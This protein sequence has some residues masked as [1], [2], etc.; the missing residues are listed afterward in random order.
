M[1]LLKRDFFFGHWRFFFFFNHWSSHLFQSNQR[2]QGIEFVDRTVPEK[3]Y[4]FNLPCMAFVTPRYLSPIST[5]SAR[6]A[7]VAGVKRGRRRGNL[8]ARGRKERNACKETIVFSIFHAQIL[9]VKIVV[10][11]NKLNVNLFPISRKQHHAIWVT[12]HMLLV[13]R[14][15]I[16]LREF[17]VRRYQKFQ[18]ERRIEKSS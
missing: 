5:V 18:L 14:D 8:G 4:I 10:G 1:R 11:Q 2:F 15:E 17:I 3:L 7:C 6:I 16:S 13:K 12:K 9:S